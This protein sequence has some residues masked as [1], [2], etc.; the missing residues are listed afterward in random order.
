MSKNAVHRRKARAP[1]PTQT[2]TTSTSRNYDAVARELV[3]R[4]LADPAILGQSGHSP[5]HAATPSDSA[6]PIGSAAAPS[7]GTRP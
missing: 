3:R 7:K 2:Q 5:D 1:K 4:G 6:V